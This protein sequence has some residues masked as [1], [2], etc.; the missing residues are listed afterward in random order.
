[1]IKKYIFFFF[2]ANLLCNTTF[3][4]ETSSSDE[5]SIWNNGIDDI[6]HLKGKNSNLKKAFDALKQA[7]RYEKKGKADKAIKRFE[8]VIKFFTLANEEN[9]NDPVCIKR[10]HKAIR[11]KADKKQKEIDSKKKRKKKQL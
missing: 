2:I 6:S 10:K 5:K 3:S 11:I 7:K 8:D 4:A 1:M 9:P